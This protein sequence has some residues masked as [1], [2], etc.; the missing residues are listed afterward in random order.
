MEIAI[1]IGHGAHANSE[2][3]VKI[4]NNVYVVFMT[5]PGYLGHLQN[6]TSPNF[7]RTF[8]NANRVKQL[9]RGEIPRNQLPQIVT[10]KEWDWRKH[11]YAPG[12]LV[13]NHILELFDRGRNQENK[14]YNNICGLHI[15]GTPVRGWGRGETKTLRDFMKRVSEVAGRRKAV[16]FISG[17]R[18]DP[19]I[20][21]TSIKE[22]LNI[23]TKTGVEKLVGPRTYHIT[24]TPHIN[25]IIKQEGN[26]T[27]Y[28]TKKRIK[29]NNSS[30]QKRIRS[31]TFENFMKN[32]NNGMTTNQ[33]KRKYPVSYT[34]FN[35]LLNVS[36]KMKKMK[37]HN[38]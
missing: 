37:I 30:P 15:L 20:T 33:L 31:W 3:I 18:G 10:Q 26:V 14:N 8:S 9:V 22:A 1:A 13:H 16:L 35:K 19:R 12:M 29:S 23:N 21:Q 2:P 25:K 28:M 4:P 27:R 36:A 38:R 32:K 11:V 5:E 34:F 24:T 17:C 7:I 6:S